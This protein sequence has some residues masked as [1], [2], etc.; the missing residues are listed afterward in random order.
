[1]VTAQTSSKMPLYLVA[2]VS[3]FT[4][5]L[6]NNPLLVRLASSFGSFVTLLNSYKILYLEG[7]LNDV[8]TTSLSFYF[9]LLHKGKGLTAQENCFICEQKWYLYISC[10]SRTKIVA[11]PITSQ[12]PPYP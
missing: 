9:Q 6:L 7:L 1:M 8:R 12:P 2:D 11:A 4:L 10:H 3:C 5:P